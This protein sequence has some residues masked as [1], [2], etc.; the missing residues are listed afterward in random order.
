MSM[1]MGV[2]RQ[3]ANRGA[4]RFE[5]RF[6]GAPSELW[7]YLTE[8]EHLSQW[9]TPGCTIEPRVGGRIVFPWRKGPAMQGEITV[10][11]PPHRMEYFWREGEVNSVVKLEL[12]R[13]GGDT[14][15]IV[16]HSGLPLSDHGGF[17][18]GW[19]SHLD[20]LEQVRVGR[21]AEHD[22][23]ARFMEMAKQYGWEPPVSA[24]GQP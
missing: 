9:I 15:L 5:R 17:A 22:H 10:F 19:H 23:E 11:E 3:E 16:D 12:K 18:A 6:E 4:V 2:L 13:A 20:W 21:G 8:A 24:A 14:I 7:P 1:Q